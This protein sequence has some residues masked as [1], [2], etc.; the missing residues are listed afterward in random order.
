MSS[1]NANLEVWISR[2]LASQ[3][4]GN[5]K[6]VLDRLAGD[7]SNRT[8]YRLK[9]PSKTFVVLSDPGWHLS[10]DYLPHQAYLRSKGL[11]VPDFGKEDPGAGFLVMEDLGDELLQF[12][13]QKEP[14]SRL[15]WLRKMT[16]LLAELHGRTFPVPSTLP[17]AT[18]KFDGEKYSQEMAFTFEHLVV[19]FLGYPPPNADTVRIIRD[20]CDGL[21]KIRPEVFAHRDYH[22]RN[23]ILNQTRLFLI[24]FQD[25]RL[26]PPHYDLVSLIYD[27]YV[28]ISDAERKELVALYRTKVKPFPLNSQI[29][30][31]CFDDDLAQVA[32]Q[33]VVK[34]AGSFA[35]FFTRYGKSTHLP[36]LRPALEMARNLQRTS[37]T[38]PPA[39]Q[40][41]FKIDEWL[42]KLTTKGLS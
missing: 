29:D 16:E 28:P 5:E 15:D 8:F 37:A 30:W 27:A 39:L 18:R 23:V 13:I 14:A 33:R 24:D 17:I 20:Y 25:A 3:G 40:S 19:G 7:G 1:Q 2:W 4:L 38:L 22:T 35:S 32:F 6:P 12:R 31:S 41:V 21:A 34:A 11:P 10:K 36:Y 26:G 9:L 42:G